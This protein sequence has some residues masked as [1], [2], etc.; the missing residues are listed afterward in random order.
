MKSVSKAFSP[1]YGDRMT[2]APASR[3]S[4]KIP[5]HDL[6][7]PDPTFLRKVLQACLMKKT[8]F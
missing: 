2:A 4:N 1:D 6:L 3:V 8:K 5:C 7:T